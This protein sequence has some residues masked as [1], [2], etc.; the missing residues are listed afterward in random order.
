M[1]VPAEID[2]SWAQKDRLQLMK[3]H[4]ALVA[5]NVQPANNKKQCLFPIATFLDHT[6][7]LHGDKFALWTFSTMGLGTELK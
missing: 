7:W 5:A 3:T 1:M 2:Y 6:N 4:I